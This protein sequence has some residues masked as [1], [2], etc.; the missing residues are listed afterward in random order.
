VAIAHKIIV[1]AHRMLST[2]V[3]YKELS[4]TYLD[5]MDE[6]R[7]ANNLIRRL[8]RLGYTVKLERT[9][10]IVTPAEVLFS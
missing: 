9:D 10:T 4:D 8:E 5:Q 7:T 3:P 6:K 1:A 2:D